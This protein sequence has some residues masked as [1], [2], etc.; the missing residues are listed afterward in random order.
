MRFWK[1]SRN[2]GMMLLAVWMILFGI[3]TAPVLNLN[4]GYEGD[5][6]ALFAVA[7]GILLL[8]GK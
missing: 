1:S 7:V 3:L 4:F 5:L 6:L 8:L 2:F